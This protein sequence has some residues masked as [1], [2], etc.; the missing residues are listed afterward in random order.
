[1][2]PSKTGILLIAFLLC[3]ASAFLWVGKWRW[4]LVYLALHIASVVI[5]TSLAYSGLEPLRAWGQRRPE[6]VLMLA[7]ALVA[8]PAFIHA[9]KFLDEPQRNEW[10]GKWYVVVAAYVAIGIS[11]YHYAKPYLV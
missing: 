11:I 1:M 2:K 3:P 4:G 8:L 6:T 5:I 9:S 10:F 7:N